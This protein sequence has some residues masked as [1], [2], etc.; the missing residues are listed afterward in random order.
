MAG[1]MMASA[2][3]WAVAAAAALVMAL[4]AGPGAGAP[5]VAIADGRGRRVAAPPAALLARAEANGGWLPVI[6]GLDLPFVPEGMLDAA[7]VAAQR[8]DIAA[9]QAALLAR[10]DAPEAVKRFA[11]VPYLAFAARADDLAAALA[12]PGVVSVREDVP[13]PP[14]LADSVPLIGAPKLWRQGLRGRG[15]VVAVLDSGVKL[16][17]P[18]FAGRIALLFAYRKCLMMKFQ[19]RVPIAPNFMNIPDIIIRRR[20]TCFIIYLIFIV[21]RFVIDG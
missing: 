6:V 21:Q 9:A 4:A 10:L 2:M 14:A 13:E 12:A 20:F 11:T 17:H 7:A 5:D 18:A 15:W 16:D 8:R 19:C 1:A 3:R